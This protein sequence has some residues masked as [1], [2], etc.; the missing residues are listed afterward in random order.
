MQKIFIII[1]REYWVRVR[2]RSFLIMTFLTPLLMAALMIVPVL[3]AT[4]FEKVKKVE[5]IDQSGQILSKIED[6]PKIKFVKSSH[7]ELES[8]KKSLAKSEN[9]AIL[10]I[11]KLDWA[12]I[13]PQAIQIVAEK[14]ISLENELDIKG[15]IDQAIESIRYQE[16]GID[17][18]KLEQLNVSV[19][20][21][22][23]TTQGEESSSAV[24][25]I[26]GI[27]VAFVVY[28]SVFLY[29]QQVMR[30]VIEEKSNRIVEVIVSSVKPFELMMGKIVGVGLIGLT[31]FVLWIGLTFAIYTGV[32]SAFDLG[33]YVNPS[34][35]PAEVA[36]SKGGDALEKEPIE[37][38]PAQNPQIQK[39]L[40]GLGNFPIV[41]VVAGFLF[42]FL[43]GYLLYS[44]MFA[45]VASAVDNEADTQQFV[46]PISLPLIIAFVA[47]QAVINDPDGP[48]A[49]W[50]SIIPFTSP[51]IMVIRLAFGGVPLWE[52]LLS[53]ALLTLA[54]IGITWVAARI[55]RIGILMY[56]KKPTF[57]DLGK[58]I[59][60]KL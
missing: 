7:T 51:I 57:K 20:L 53:M 43:G 19:V 13:P 52:L 48:M 40:T 32:A 6:L 50:M 15:R 2:K 60:Y 1:Q 42:Y 54:F 38:S 9:F 8:A 58:W 56:G 34:P 21:A 24:A 36:N 59:F 33:Q 11:P 55:Y 28:M 46:L 29:G 4:R 22:T 44:A 5:V 41:S 31:Q 27:I 12:N 23:S 37:K 49:F 25:F 14:S 45:A 10:F 3:L 26:I 39:I 18:K 30:G 16:A 35:P 17:P 47:F